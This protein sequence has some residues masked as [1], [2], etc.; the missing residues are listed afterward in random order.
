MEKLSE[1]RVNLVFH[2]N[3]T[4]SDSSTGLMWMLP[5]VGQGWDGNSATG[6][7]AAYAWQEAT[8]RYGRGR[9]I[10]I[11]HEHPL[12]PYWE[13]TDS[14]RPQLTPESYEDYQFGTKKYEFAGFKDWRMPIVEEAFALMETAVHKELAAFRLG[15]RMCT[16]NPSTISQHERYERK[17]RRSVLRRMLG[18]P[19]TPFSDIWVWEARLN[20]DIVFG[21]HPESD[22]Y[23]VRLVRLG[24][25]FQATH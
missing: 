5:L 11:P 7:N 10:E 15:F 9:L 3:G 16:A 1:K 13:V 23:W 2:D 18:N 24:N 21:D 25:L 12:Q 17:A 19:Y 6:S 4:M 14:T 8:E 22:R 20:R